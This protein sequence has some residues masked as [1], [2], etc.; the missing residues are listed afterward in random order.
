MA[1]LIGLMGL[2]VAGIVALGLA[3]ELGGGRLPVS[4]RWVRGV[5]A[6]NVLV[7]ALALAGLLFFAAQDVLAQTAQAGAAREVSVGLGL[8]LIGVGIPTAVASI[9]AA[10]A[11]G[12]VGA[13]ALAVLAEKPEIFGRTLVYLG[14]AE[15][16]AIYGLVVSILIL[17]KL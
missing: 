12:P 6:G 2:A 11:L 15:G 10:I 5:L 4:T 7:F 9:G 8:A 1:W 3:L 17:G 13:A 14:L 16:I